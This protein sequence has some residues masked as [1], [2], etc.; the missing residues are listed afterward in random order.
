ND[1]VRPEQRAVLAHMPTLRL[2]TP[3]LGGGVESVGWHPL[4]PILFRVEPGKMVPNN[5]V[6]RVAF[7]ARCPGVPARDDAI[8]VQHVER[9]VGH[10]VDE[11]AELALA[12]PQRLVRRA[13]LCDIPGDLGIADEIAV[14]IVNG[15]DDNRGPE[16]A[17]I[18]SAAPAF[19]L[20]AAFARRDLQYT[21]RQPGRTVL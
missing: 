11:E 12:V 16:A 5:L 19:G 6:G 8:E 9:V 14:I 1:G 21:Q 15:I 7:D 10:A 20:V 13:P 4:R 3:L 2:V 18:F 17:A